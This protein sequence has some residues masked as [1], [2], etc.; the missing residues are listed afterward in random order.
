MLSLK[1]HVGLCGI[2]SCFVKIKCCWGQ[3][4]PRCGF[5][6]LLIVLES[7]AA[8]DRLTL[9]FFTILEGSKTGHTHKSKQRMGAL[10]NHIRFIDDTSTCIYPCWKNDSESSGKAVTSFFHKLSTDARETHISFWTQPY[11]VAIASLTKRS[12]RCGIWV[13]S[14]GHYLNSMV[15]GFERHIHSSPHDFL[16]YVSFTPQCLQEV[17]QAID[18]LWLFT[19]RYR[20]EL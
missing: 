18:S 5:I 12:I 10:D 9:P 16:L 17:Q 4:V 19:V 7:V 20:H 11:W 2:C 1:H 3:S 13:S 6:V 15:S 14:W 8:D